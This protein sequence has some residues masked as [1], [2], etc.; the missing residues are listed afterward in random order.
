[1]KS[2]P[3]VAV[4][5]AAKHA[6]KLAC[7]RE[8]LSTVEAQIALDDLE[9]RRDKLIEQIAE[10]EMVTKLYIGVAKEVCGDMTALELLDVIGQP[11]A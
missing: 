8:D 4:R 6:F 7:L 1:M 5:I 3:V 10:A 9:Y 2:N 11:D